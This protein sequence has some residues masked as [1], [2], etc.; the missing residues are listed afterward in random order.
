MDAWE[1]LMDSDPQAVARAR[2]EALRR[3][4]AAGAMLLGAGGRRLAPLGARMMDVQGQGEAATNEAMGQRLRM[5]MQ[6]RAAAAG[7]AEQ[8]R[9][10]EMDLRKQ[11]EAERHNRAME[12]RPTGPS[13]Q[14]VSGEGG[15]QFYADPRNPGAPAVPVTGPDGRPIVKTRAMRPLSSADRRELQDLSGESRALVDLTQRFRP[16]FAGGGP[17]GSLATSAYQKL[18]SW[19]PDSKQADA[20]FWA[21]FSRLVDLPQRNRIFGASLSVNEKASWD[22]AKNI[23]PGTDPALVQQKL[24]EMRD[25]YSRKMSEYAQSLIADGYDPDAVAALVGGQADAPRPPAATTAGAAPR[26]RRF[27]PQTGALE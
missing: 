7:A 9:A 11:T 15:A 8:Q 25:I 23:R 24:A 6:E 10:Y 5:A 26:R 27:N 1:L 3:Q 16:E 14:I 13:F 22:Q 4:G 21:D 12:A 18:G 2:A 17:G 19:A 20:A